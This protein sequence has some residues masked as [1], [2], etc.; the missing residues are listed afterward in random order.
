MRQLI[1][2]MTGGWIKITRD[3]RS[4]WLWSDPVKFQWWID[5]LME[6]NYEPKKVLIKGKVLDCGRGQCLY[7]LDSWAQRWRTTKKTVSRFFSALEADHKIDTESMTVCTR[8]TVCDYDSYKGLVNAVD[9]AYNPGCN[10]AH[11]TAHDPQLKK[12]RQER[13]K[14]ERMDAVFVPPSL[15]E[16]K[17]YFDEKGY[18]E[19]AAVKAWEYYEAGNWKDSNKKQ[20]RNWKQKMVA[21][22]FKPEYEKTTGHDKHGTTANKTEMVF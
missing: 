5:I 18:S 4:N 6:V 19:Q 16:V 2:N 21:V 12:E 14:E 11:D 7:S 1:T 13:K 3:I 17:A 10:P 15:F 20:V 9:P 22:W 8:I